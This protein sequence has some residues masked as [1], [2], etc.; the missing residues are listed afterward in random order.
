MQTRIIASLM[1]ISIVFASCSKK[2]LPA[3]T[4]PPSS[5]DIEE[6]DFEYLD[7][8]AKLH[9]KDDKKEKQVTATIRIRKDSIVWMQLSLAGISGGRVLIN[10]DSVTVMSL[11]DKE[12]YVYSY[13]ELSKRFNFKMD[14]HTI[15]SAMLGNLILPKTETDKVEK[16]T[17]FDL[18]DQSQGTMVIKNFINSTTKK[19]ERL[20][21][22]ENT[23]N[24]SLKINYSNF[25]PVNE[26]TFPF[27]GIISVLYHTPVGMINNSISIE[28]TRVEVGNKELRF[29]FKIPKRYERR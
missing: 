27:T 24:N 16:T 13:E 2:A 8:K 9:Y 1:L 12:Y 3:A 25:Q 6:I 4:I 23:S 26:K 29:P 28:Y 5:L 14:Y 7:G 18:L 20:E 21:M 11:V 17:G 19:L 15:Q 22:M 10:Q